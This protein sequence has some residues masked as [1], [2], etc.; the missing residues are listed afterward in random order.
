METK[1]SKKNDLERV[2]SIFFQFG[3][4]ISLAIV[5]TAFEWTT[6]YNN[7]EDLG[8]LIAQADNCELTP[9]TF[10]K[11]EIKPPAP[12]IIL[13]D[14]NIVKDDVVVNDSIQIQSTD[15]YEFKPNDSILAVFEPEPE[16]EE[17]TMFWKVEIKPEFK[18]GEK[19]MHKY[20]VDYTSY[21]QMPK[22]NFIQGTVY[23]EFTIDK[24]G[25]IINPKIKKGVDPY[26]D[27]EAL[28]VVSSMPDWNPGI[29]AGKPVSVTN[30]IPIKFKLSN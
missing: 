18:G 24:K 4:I 6:Y 8:V 28:R 16:T 29:Q 13:T 25:K 14:I 23:I 17:P 11:E 15:P 27:K 20:I 1:K 21:P 22:E 10:M 26:L 19:N 5:I 2:K 3:L 7:S 12:K 9:L 30:V